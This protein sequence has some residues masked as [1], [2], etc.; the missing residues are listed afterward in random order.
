MNIRKII[1]IN[2]T[3]KENNFICGSNNEVTYLLGSSSWNGSPHRY[4]VTKSEGNKWVIPINIVK[5]RLGILMERQKELE[6]KIDIIKQV[7]Q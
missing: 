3:K 6:E 4:H 7:L 2:I 5:E 1:R